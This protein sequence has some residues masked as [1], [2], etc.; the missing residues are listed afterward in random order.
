MR[1]RRVM[2]GLAQQQLIPGNVGEGSINAGRFDLELSNSIVAGNTRAG[3][4]NPDVYGTITFCNGHNVFGSDIGANP[5][6]D[7]ENIAAS[8]IFAAIDPGTGGGQL[9]AS[10]VAPLRN[11]LDNPAL[12]GADL[13]RRV[14]PISSAPRALS[15]PATCP[16]SARSR[17]TMRS[18]PSSANNDL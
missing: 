18:R 6:G 2:L 17:S 3:I 14:P 4:P 9:N 1:E 10:G 8:A 11:A 15:R 13:W 16:T 12:S 7:R 5:A